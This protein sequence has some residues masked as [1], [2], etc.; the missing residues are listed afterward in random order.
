MLP[1]MPSPALGVKVA[2]YT[3]P[4]PLAIKVEIVPPDTV[5]SPDTK[6]DVASLTVKVN[7]AESPE[8]KDVRSVATETVGTT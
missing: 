7:V 3:V 8:T 5:T 1:A 6:F 2:V 4:A